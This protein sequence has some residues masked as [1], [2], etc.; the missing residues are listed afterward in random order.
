VFKV[1]TIFDIKINELHPALNHLE[2]GIHYGLESKPFDNSLSKTETETRRGYKEKTKQRLAKGHLRRCGMVEESFL[3]ENM[4]GTER[5]VKKK[6][7]P[8]GFCTYG[9]TGGIAILYYTVS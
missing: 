5:P 4:T 9:Q 8:I 1:I 7:W 3:F 2:N 6:I